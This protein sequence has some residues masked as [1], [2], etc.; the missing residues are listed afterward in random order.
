LALPLLRDSHEGHRDGHS[1]RYQKA[2]R[3]TLLG[4]P[5]HCVGAAGKEDDVAQIL[6]DLHRTPEPRKAEVIARIQD[7]LR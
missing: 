2:K 3:A 7:L 6:V 1:N 4:G 5:S